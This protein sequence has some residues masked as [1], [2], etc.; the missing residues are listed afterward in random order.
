MKKILSIVGA[1]PQF[2]KAFVTI[3]SI[4]KLKNINN[5]LLHTG[6][7]FD[8]DM[9]K[10]FFKELK[11]NKNL[12]KINL[13]V[14]QNRISRLSEMLFKLDKIINK[15]KPQL[16]LVYGDTDTTLAGSIVA[17]RLN[18][19][20]MHIESGLRSNV[21]EMPEEQNRFFTDYLSDY[22]ICPN[23]ESLQNLITYKNKGKFNYGDVMYD[24]F[25]FYSKFI[26]KNYFYKFKIKYKLPKKY[27]FV[28]IHRDSNSKAILIKKFLNSLSKINQ[29]FFWPIHPKLRIIINKNKIIIPN[30]VISS[31][32]ISYLECLAAIK[33]SDF[34]L[35]DS[36]GVQKEAHFYR[37]KCFV[38]RKETEWKDLIKTNTVK[39]I[40]FNINSIKK[41]NKFLKKKIL[42]TKIFGNGGSTEKIAKLVNRILK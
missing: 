24:S 31:K 39:L 28:T 8:Y 5:I 4:N 37:K 2:I 40:S 23:N 9:S 19:K 6:Q 13:K 16:I 26:D 41:S 18:I 34:V 7:H 42:N 20:L 17:K 11:F 15:I 12:I 29:I 10:I 25:K 21:T 22:L 36:G 14:N 35:T 38:L 30:N 32:P 33:G 1:R 27:L 3:N